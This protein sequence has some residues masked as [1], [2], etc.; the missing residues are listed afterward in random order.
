MDVSFLP[1]SEVRAG[2]RLAAGRLDA[3]LA[4]AAPALAAAGVAVEGLSN[5]SGIDRVFN[6]DFR[7]RQRLDRRTRESGCIVESA[8]VLDYLEPSSPGERAE[9][10]WNLLAQ[11]FAPGQPSWFGWREQRA[12]TVAECEAEGFG[13]LLL[14]SIRRAAERLP[15]PY[16]TAWFESGPAIVAGGSGPRAT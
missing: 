6:L 3:A 4:R 16:R 12:G 1:E 5:R 13:R 15:E 2:Y 9:V 10:R 8:V 11:V 14:D 7:W